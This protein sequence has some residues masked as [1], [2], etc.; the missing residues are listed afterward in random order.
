MDQLR[1]QG[2]IIYRTDEHGEITLEIDKKMQI[3]VKPKVEREKD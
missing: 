1:E 2:I 3:N